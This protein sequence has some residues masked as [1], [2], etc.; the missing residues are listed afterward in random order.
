[1]DGQKPIIFKVKKVI[2]YNGDILEDITATIGHGFLIVQPEADQ[3]TDPEA[4]PSWYNLNSVEAMQ[5]VEVQAEQR[6]GRIA[7]I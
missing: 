6:K 7:M 5:N 3:D 2:F 1:M 4:A